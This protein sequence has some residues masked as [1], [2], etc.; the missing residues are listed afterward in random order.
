MNMSSLSPDSINPFGIRFVRNTFIG[1]DEKEIKQTSTEELF[2]IRKAVSGYLSSKKLKRRNANF[3]EVYGRINQ[4]L[5]SRGV[6]PKRAPLHLTTKKTKKMFATIKSQP[7]TKS[8]SASSSDENFE[9]KFLGKKSKI[10]FQIPEFLQDKIDQKFEIM[11]NLLVLNDFVSN[12]SIYKIETPQTQERKN[13]DALNFSLIKP[14]IFCPSDDFSFEY[15]RDLKEL[16]IFSKLH[17]I[18]E[19]NFNFDFN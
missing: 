12:N 6:I 4:E 13:S 3:K 11:K 1:F 2:I 16:D 7:S 5:R 10:D 17:S 15:D 19:K 14:D 9:K 18:D 8:V